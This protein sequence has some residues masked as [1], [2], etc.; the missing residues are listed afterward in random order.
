ML[1]VRRMS[2]AI[3]LL[4]APGARLVRA[5]WGMA[6]ALCLVLGAGSAGAGSRLHPERWY[7]ERW[8]AEQ[9]GT[10]EVVLEDGSRCDCLT[11]TH[12][13]EFDFANKWAEAVGQSLHYANLSRKRAGIVIIQERPGDTRY[14]RRL[15]GVLERYDLPVDLWVEEP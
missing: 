9:G 14:L 12:A 13:V 3:S 6:L 15:R 7:Q 1:S 2:K 10:M 8:C 5:G 4:G 11:A